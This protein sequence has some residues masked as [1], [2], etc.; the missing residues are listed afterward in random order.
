MEGVEGRVEGFIRGCSQ[1]ANRKGWMPVTV[2]RGDVV[3]LFAV[4]D[5]KRRR[6]TTVPHGL[7]P[8]Q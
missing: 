8:Q 5:R 6:V 2:A 3:A 7:N 4:E 1:A